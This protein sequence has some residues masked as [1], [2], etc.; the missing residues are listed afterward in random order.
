MGR[1]I[2][3][4]DIVEWDVTNWS[5]ALQYWK[6]NSVHKLALVKAL[7][8]G[9]RN[10][11]LS[12]WLALGGARVLCTDLGAP[13]AK[14][15]QKHRSFGVAHRIEYEALDATDIPY[16]DRFDLV[17]FKS[18][19]GG[20]G[21]SNR[22]DRQE[23]AIREIHKSLKK[24]GE[25]W[26]AENLIGSPIHRFFRT[27]CIPWGKTWRYVSIEEMDRFLSVFAEVKYTTVGF[28]G[29]FGRNGQGQALLGSLDR[30]IVDRLVPAAWRYVAVGI[31]RK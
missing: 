24:G 16:V 15:I 6:R 23:K 10:G 30:L 28:L 18:V 13:A 20:I 12:L 1:L 8:I 22:I 11:G 14:A 25:L 27:R 17:L 9:S 4:G 3:P 21:R 19:L 5:V 29:A 31:A 26:F 2:T 7:E